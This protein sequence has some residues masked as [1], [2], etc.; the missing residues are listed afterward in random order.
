MKF[1]EDYVLPISLI[2]GHILLFCL[3]IPAPFNSENGWVVPFFGIL[4]YLYGVSLPTTVVPF[5]KRII[6]RIYREATE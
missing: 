6:A 4:H 2:I 5:I 1:F 3:L